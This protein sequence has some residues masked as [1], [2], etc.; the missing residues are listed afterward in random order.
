MLGLYIFIFGGL[1]ALTRV[2][3]SAQ[4][5]NEHF[6]PGTLL[7]NVLG[8]LAL[9]VL[10]IYYQQHKYLFTANI[11]VGVMVGF[12]GALTTFSTFSL[13]TIRLVE[14]NLLML[15]SMNILLNV[16]LSLVFCGIG[17]MS[18]KYIISH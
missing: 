8:S 3:L 1:G 12:L 18:A 4:F 9:G 11:H 5:K 7:V 16:L 13:E 6:A 17:I 15:A 2:S 10:F 14:K